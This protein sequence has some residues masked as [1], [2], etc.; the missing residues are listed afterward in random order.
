VNFIEQVSI[1]RGGYLARV[2]GARESG[3]GRFDAYAAEIFLALPDSGDLLGNCCRLDGAGI[4]DGALAI[5]D[6]HFDDRPF[7]VTAKGF[8]GLDIRCLGFNWGGCRFRLAGGF[9]GLRPLPLPMDAL[10]LWFHDWIGPRP[11]AD[12]VPRSSADI[13]AWVEANPC[14]PADAEGR[15]RHLGA[16]HSVSL[17]APDQFTVDFGSAPL[18]AFDEL[19]A[20]LRGAGAKKIFIEAEQDRRDVLYGRIL[21]LLQRQDAAAAGRA[22]GQSHGASHAP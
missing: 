21:Q 16:I 4:K 8:G 9:M 22:A 11:P 5:S 6:I 7:D 10:Q 15:E 12:Q 20:T 3:L 13:M 14:A 2:V 19:L 18:A 17:V 1:A